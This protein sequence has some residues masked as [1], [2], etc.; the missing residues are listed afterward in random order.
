M[1][2]LRRK[3]QNWLIKEYLH[4]VIYTMARD[5]VIEHSA[6][7]DEEYKRKVLKAVRDVVHDAR[8]DVI[9]SQI[10]GSNTGR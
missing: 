5:A 6:N 3:I 9:K 1:K 8:K 7:H 10:H 2:W 4:E